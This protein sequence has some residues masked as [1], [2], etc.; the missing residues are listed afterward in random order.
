MLEKYTYTPVKVYTTINPLQAKW[1]QVRLKMAGVISETT[2]NSSLFP[3][4]PG[5]GSIDVLVDITNVPAARV[6]LGKN[7]VAST[8]K[9][10]LRNCPFKYASNVNTFN[11]K[12]LRR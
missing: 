6:I 3:L 11:R 12:A 8:H 1:A 4:V 9:T 10:A 7:F 2:D 5:V